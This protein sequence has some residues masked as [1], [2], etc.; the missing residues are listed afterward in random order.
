MFMRSSWNKFT[1]LYQNSVSFR[2]ASA[3]PG[4]HQHG[5]SIQISINLGKTFLR[6]SRKR[7]VLVTWI[8]ARVSVY[9]PPCIFQILDFIY[10]TVLNF[11]FFLINFEWRDTENQQFDCAVNEKCC[12]VDGGPGICSLFSSP[13]RGIWQLKS[14]HPQEFAFLGKKKQKKNSNAQESAW[15]VGA[16]GAAGI[17][18]CITATSMSEFGL[19]KGYFDR[20]YGTF[21]IWLF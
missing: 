13:L 12:S 2:H 14:P 4:G 3:H 21:I 1:L 18:W 8:L 15:E 19:D 11:F 5:V 6:I 9:L 20:I 17:G 16:L 7:N 10:W